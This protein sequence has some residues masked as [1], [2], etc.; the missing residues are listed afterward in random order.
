MLDAIKPMDLEMHPLASPHLQ[1]VTALAT[2][3]A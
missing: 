1:F 3:E 2:V